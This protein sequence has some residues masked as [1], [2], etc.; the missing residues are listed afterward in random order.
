MRGDLAVSD[1]VASHCRKRRLQRGEKLCLELAVDL[2]SCEVACDI[3]DNSCIE[4]DRIHYSVAVLS[5]TCEGNIE[6]DA[7]IVILYPERY[8]IGR[9]VLVAHDLLR[10]YEVYS[11]ILSRH[12][13]ELES[14]AYIGKSLFEAG[15]EVPV[16]Q[17]RLRLAVEY[18]FSGLS[19]E[20]QNLAL[21][22]DDHALSVCDSDYGPVADDVVRSVIRSASASCRSLE[23]H[24]VRNGFTVEIVSP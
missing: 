13:S 24:F 23:K 22:D 7:G 16:K 9:S 2:V 8:G 12:S 1:A 6:V 10:I 15:P 21:L 18:I 17:R 5:E 19:A 11:L 20:I 4:K 3:S 14:L